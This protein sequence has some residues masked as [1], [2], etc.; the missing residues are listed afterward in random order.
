MCSSRSLRWLSAVVVLVNC[1]QG[2]V[3]HH[4]DELVFTPAIRIDTL[5]H[6]PVIEG[7]WEV[8]DDAGGPLDT[9]L[10][11]LEPVSG[12][13]RW[14]GPLNNERRIMVRYRV[15]S[16]LVPRLGPA[17]RYLPP[18]GQIVADSTAPSLGSGSLPSRPGEGNPP[19]DR[20]VTAGSLF[21]GL[22]VSSGRGVN[23][24]GGLNLRLQGELGGGVF[25]NGSLTDQNIPIQPEGDTRTLNELDQVRLSLTSRWGEVEVG[26]FILKGQGGRMASFERKLEGMRV[27]LQG[28]D[29][30]VIGALAGSRGRYRSQLI[31][32]QDGRQGPY[33]LLTHE[34]SRTMIVLPGT[35]VVWLNGQRLQRGESLDYTIDYTAGE[36]SFTPRHSI[37][38]DSRIVVDFEYTDLVFNRLTSYLATTWRGERSSLTVSALTERDDLQSNLE[39][40]LSAEDQKY[41]REIGDREQEAII[42]TAAPDPA[43]SYDLVDGHY[44]WR[45]ENQGGYKVSFFNVG[46]QGCYRR[47]VAGDR[48]IYQWVPPEE[49]AMYNA[50]Y[51][52]FRILKLPQRLDLMTTSWQLDGKSEGRSARLEVGLSHVDLNRYSPLDD[53]DNLDAGYALQLQWKTEPLALAGRTLRAGLQLDGLGK[54]QQ[55]TPPGRWDAVEFQREWD[56]DGQPKRYNWQTVNLFLEETGHQRVF[57]QLGRIGADSIRTDR[58]SWG[59]IKSG[60]APLA[61]GFKQTFLSRVNGDRAWQITDS[62][63]KYNFKKFAPFVRY[64]SEN[65]QRD[66]ASSYQVE[67]LTLGLEARI[68]QQTRLG[69]SRELR[70]DIFQAG[71]TETAHLWLLSLARTVPRGTRLETTLSF[72][73][74]V[75]SDERDD[76]SYMM[77]DLA[78]VHRPVGRPWWLD[79]RYRLE[80]KIAESKAV[81]YDSVGTGLGQYRFDPVYKTYVPDEAGSY[82]RF[83][84]PAGEI[85]PINTVKSRFRLQVDLNRTRYP[86]GSIKDYVVARLIIQGQLAAE[87]LKHSLATYL[88]PSLDDSAAVNVHSRLQLDLALQSRPRQPQYRLRLIQQTRLNRENIGGN[89]G[90]MPLGEVLEQTSAELVQ[91]SRHQLAG[92]Q[93]N[94]EMRLIHE[95]KALQSLISSLRNH[96]ILKWQGQGTASGALAKRLTTS[97]TGSWQQ[98]VDRDLEAL[99]VRTIAYGGGLQLT[100][101]TRGHLRVDLEHFHVAASRQVP[102]PY[103]MA[104]GFPSG[105]SQRLRASG[106][107][108]LSRNLLLSI[109]LFS[110]REAGRAPFTNANLEL[111]TQ[112]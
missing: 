77:G 60:T 46:D 72:N 6:A 98:E 86:I 95:R 49:A 8:F 23:L 47:V 45:G 89:G 75:A 83:V 30:Q 84:I 59:L 33:A 62:D 53:R 57:A 34:G 19:A 50:N 15:V 79:L 78:L 61:G 36:I 38:S 40:S 71:P 106:Q 87:I 55:F 13:V 11:R 93:V 22:S 66:I 48:V 100:V 85:R 81:I 73:E 90:D 10:V 32:G 17:W 26:D 92:R 96:D 7:S 58:L 80:R 105:R 67:Q 25:I 5:A 35:E 97:V 76:L 28:G 68:S 18:L 112:F 88:K 103:L 70:R 16:G 37:R 63:L 20:L 43:G 51:A 41:L 104:Q 52:P 54:G 108:H 9:A 91:I 101:G 107:F 2:Q 27:Q 31:Q 12:S 82:N 42:P 29:W 102:I 65:R 1:L 109:T 99:Q 4:Q 14:L 39:F 74:K 111:R 69:L 56:L 44:L 64:Y 21:R 110:R 24:T 94:R 3:E